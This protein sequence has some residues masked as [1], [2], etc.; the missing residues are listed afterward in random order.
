V[1]HA[2]VLRQ[3]L[4]GS[5]LISVSIAVE[6]VFIGLAVVTLRRL[7]GRLVS[8]RRVA[9]QILTLIVMTLWL[10]VALGVGVWLWAVAFMILGLFETLEA[11]LY[12]S[13][14]AFTTLGFGDVT[15][16]AEWRLLSGFIAANGLVLFSLT[17]A[18]LIELMR[19]LGDPRPNGR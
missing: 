15:L 4:V 2:S 1:Y 3:V 9:K 16:D 18:F 11:A 19:R 12:F 17:T 5:L 14:V 8:G 10:L 7:G 6:A 13:A